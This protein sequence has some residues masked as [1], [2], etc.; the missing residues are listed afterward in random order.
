MFP[1]FSKHLATL[2]TF[3][4]DPAEYLITGGSALAVRGIRDCHDLD[5]LCSSRLAEELKSRFPEVPVKVFPY[6]ESMLLEGIEFMFNFEEK[7]RPWS[8]EQQIA[9]A[10]LIDGKRYQTLEKT[11]F[12][13]RQQNRPKDIEDLHLIEVYE[14]Q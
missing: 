5:V 2:E 9:E 10:D 3:D 11:K 6:C 7:D 1:N 14:N 8:T 4:L 13:K 12:F